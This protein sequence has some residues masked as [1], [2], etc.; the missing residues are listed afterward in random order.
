MFRPD[1]KARGWSYDA[2]FSESQ[3]THEVHKLWTPAWDNLYDAPL[4]GNYVTVSAGVPSGKHAG[5]ER[6][7]EIGVPSLPLEGINITQNV[8]V[9]E[10]RAV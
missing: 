3:R 1:S 4:F 5:Q 2:R 10:T 9:N 6:V 7:Q 8:E